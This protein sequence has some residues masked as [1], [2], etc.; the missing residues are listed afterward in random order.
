MDELSNIAP[1]YAELAVTLGHR[2]IG[3]IVK[4]MHAKLSNGPKRRTV[5]L[6]KASTQ[7]SSQVRD[8]I[9]DFDY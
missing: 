1:R 9:K 7:V 8:G 6:V 5:T 3:E 4:L 2:H